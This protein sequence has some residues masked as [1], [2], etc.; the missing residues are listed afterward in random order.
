M[1]WIAAYTERR[2]GEA[3]AVALRQ[4]QLHVSLK[5]I[6]SGHLSGCRKAKGPGRMMGLIQG[7]IGT[8]CPIRLQNVYDVVQ[9]TAHRSQ[10]NHVIG[11]ARCWEQK[12]RQHEAVTAGARLPPLSCCQHAHPLIWGRK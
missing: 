4:C 3:G 11:P 7:R 9:G 5:H 1:G 10:E 2:G 12:Q 8:L 6:S